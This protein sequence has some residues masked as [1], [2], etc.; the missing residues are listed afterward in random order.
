MSGGPTAMLD[1][2]DDGEPRQIVVSWR[3]GDGWMST[4]RQK[5]T[6]VSGTGAVWPRVWSPSQHSISEGF[7]GWKTGSRNSALVQ[8]DL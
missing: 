2:H 5:R 4:L 7:A 8:F 1:D 6:F 3:D